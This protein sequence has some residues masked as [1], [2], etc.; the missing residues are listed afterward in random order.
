MLYQHMR[1]FVFLNTGLTSFSL[2]LISSI[3]ECE[4][5][6]VFHQNRLKGDANGSMDVGL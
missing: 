1:G 6:E 3:S 4:L 2:N 5:G